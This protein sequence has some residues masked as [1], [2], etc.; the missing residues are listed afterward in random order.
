MTTENEE[1]ASTEGNIADIPTSLIWPSSEDSVLAVGDEAALGR[2]LRA[3]YDSNAAFPIEKPPQAAPWEADHFLEV[4][5]ASRLIIAHQA[6][7]QTLQ[8]GLY[9]E[10]SQWLNRSVNLYIIN[11]D[12]NQRKGRIRDP[13]TYKSDTGI[14][15][16]YR[17]TVVV[18][19]V[20]SKVIRDLLAGLVV[21]MEQY[22]G[23]RAQLVNLI[24]RE[25]QGLIQYLGR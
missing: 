16:Y 6:N 11:K 1:V 7:W 13:Y 17:S 23:A 19:G 22:T 24:G 2:I 18:Q 21:A 4:Q 3:Y 20:G 15:Q 14:M 10:L 5:Y 25:F 8:L 12:L 9:L